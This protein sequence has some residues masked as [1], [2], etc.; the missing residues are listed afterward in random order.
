MSKKTSRTRRRFLGPSAITLAA[1][2]F[3]IFDSWF[4]LVDHTLAQ[5]GAAV[6]D[7]VHLHKRVSRRGPA[8]RS[9]VQRKRYPTSQHEGRNHDCDTN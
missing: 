6:S 8:T 7:A 3:G 2:R 9:A 5:Y 4:T 1:G